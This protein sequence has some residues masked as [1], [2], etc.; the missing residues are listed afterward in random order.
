MGS[1]SS[2]SYPRDEFD[3]RDDERVPVGVH[4]APEPAWR[5]WLPLLII[6]VVV[7]ILAWGAV[8]LLGSS[9]SDTSSATAAATSAASAAATSAGQNGAGQNSSEQQ[10]GA[11]SAT[12]TQEASPAPATDADLTTG[13]TIYNGTTTNGLAGR[14]GS[15]LTNAG[16]TSVTVPGGIYESEAPTSS[17]IYYASATNEATAQALAKTLGIS[18]VVESAEGASSS[19]IVIV[20]RDDYS[21]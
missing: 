20:L 9:G 18:A 1:V 8:K 12:Q 11:G 2:Y 7:P 3:I 10:G 6:L 15:K 17:T 13:I 14:T 19:P 16:Y 5:S 4:R 21:E